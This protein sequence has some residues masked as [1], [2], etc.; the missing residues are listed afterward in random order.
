MSQLAL[1]NLHVVAVSAR[2]QA[3]Q[4]AAKESLFGQITG[5][6]ELPGSYAPLSPPSSVKGVKGRVIDASCGTEHATILVSP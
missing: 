3:Y 5:A 2:G 6:P 4:W 1:G